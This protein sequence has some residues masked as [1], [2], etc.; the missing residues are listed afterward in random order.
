MAID[1]A[2]EVLT[3]PDFLIELTIQRKEPGQFV[4]GLFTPGGTGEF[5]LSCSVQPTTAEMLSLLP[6]G[7]RDGGEQAIFSLVQLFGSSDTE[8]P[9]KVKNYLGADWIVIASAPWGH[10]G[11]YVSIISKI[12][13]DSKW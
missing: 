2:L 5:A 13:K 9:D 1:V 4:D 7:S 12:R 11:Y 6:E 10:H 8:S 3:D